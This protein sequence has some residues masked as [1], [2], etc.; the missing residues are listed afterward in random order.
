MAIPKP[1]TI[2]YETK[3]IQG[4]PNYPPEPGGVSV[5]PPRA[6]KS[7]YD[8]WGHPTGNNSTKAAAKKKMQE[9]WNDSTTP[10]L[11]HNAKF[12]YDVAITK[13]G[14]KKLPWERI[15]DT[16]YL[17]F[18]HDPH[19]RSLS[20]KPSA[21]KLL[22]M[23]PEEQDAV[24]D[25]LMQHHAAAKKAGKE[26]GAYIMDAPGSIV[27]PYADGDVVRTRGL[28]N[29]LY[30]DIV[31]RGMLNAY[32]R[33]RQLMP[34]LLDNEQ[35]GIRVD[36]AGLERDFALYTK[37]IDK[38]DAWL[39]K[40]L[41]LPAGFNIDSDDEFGKALDSNG[42]VTDWVLTKTGKKSVSKKNLTLDMYHD[43][44]VA[45]AYGYRNR[46]ATC[47][48]M[49]MGPW[50]EMAR[51]SNGWIYTTWNQVRQA[52]GD[53]GKQGTRSGRLSSTPNL[54]NISKDFETKG[55]GYSHPKFLRVP[56]L[57]LMRRYLLPDE[58][59]G[60]WLHRD[61]S[62][63]ELRILAHFEDGPLLQAYLA[64]PELD[65]HGLVGE[66]AD[67]LGIVLASRTLVKNAV[68]Q[69][70]YGGGIPAICAALHCDP[71]TAK[72]FQKAISTALPGYEELNKRVKK[73]G[74]TGEP[75]ITW[76]GR[77][78]YPEPPG[79]SDKFGRHMTFEY[80]LLNYLIQGSAA[81]CTKQA[82][83]DYHNHPKREARFLVTVHDEINV[84]SPGAKSEKARMDIAR[85]EMA[86]LK[87][88][89]LNV[90]SEGSKFDLPMLSGGKVGPTWGDSKK[91]DW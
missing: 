78:Y 74:K 91:V 65:V 50:L 12:D 11:F 76:G 73:L 75:V 62:Q 61:Y 42:I 34:I 8:G 14:L 30:Q 90:A 46:A 87:D 71:D 10:L 68:F 59:N 89:M 32:N 69:K 53:D 41:G 4:R 6:K 7:S 22:N 49:F 39:R 36:L 77:E 25:W 13:H 21:Q 38:A 5:L 82:L 33:E 26:W 67:Q 83:I 35:Q 48:R 37:A 3:A 86:I 20:L 85:R 64:N 70:V 51:A 19:A 1:A 84:S 27:G 60:M 57:P 31:D 47:L 17:L 63:Q 72:K 45:S 16:L 44:Q 43:K 23:A 66:A 56:P 55:D 18:L 54:Q 58:D 2:D 9:Y 52:H 29:Y 81:D 88:C 15:H 79:W 80:K 28:F 40:R 24:K